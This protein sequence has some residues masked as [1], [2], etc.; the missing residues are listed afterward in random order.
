MRPKRKVASKRTKRKRGASVE[1]PWINFLRD[2]KGQNLSQ[3][4]KRQLYQK[5]QQHAHAL[6]QTRADFLHVPEI[7][8]NVIPTRSSS[9]AAKSEMVIA[10]PDCFL[11]HD[12]SIEQMC[13]F[14]SRVAPLKK[15]GF[16]IT[17]I[18]GSGSYGLV[19]DLINSCGIPYVMKVSRISDTKGTPIRFPV[20]NNQKTSWHTITYRDF[21]LG[22]RAQQKMCEIF[23]NI[24]IP[25]ILHA[26]SVDLCPEERL[27]LIIMQKIE[28]ITLRKVLGST[29]IPE[30]TKQILVK[31]FG[32]LLAQL[33]KA[34]VVHGDFHCWNV[35]CDS[36]GHLYCIDFDRTCFSTHSSHRLHDIGM[37]CDT[38][39]EK[40]WPC[41][42]EAYFG[43][44]GIAIPFVLK[45]TT[46]EE[47]K[48]ELH[49]QSRELFGLY[50]AHLREYAKD[51]T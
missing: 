8:V 42:A 5:K 47:R 1:N 2:V 27:G 41:F 38:M 22:V 12:M 7:K 28:G 32:K 40:Y 17:G 51:V 29:A 26:G 13:L 37:G 45:T 11:T 34:K 10:G 33:H 30:E 23:K 14:I 16:Q 18:V 31:K 6:L 44:P 25:K 46:K 19:L 9:H 21:K 3:Q 48:R 4:A 43:V 39:D 36:S 49:E 24:R 20:L 35:L 15:L 50:L